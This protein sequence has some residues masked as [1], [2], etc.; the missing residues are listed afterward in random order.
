M[1][2]VR[3]TFFQFLQTRR[4]ESFR[5]TLSRSSGKSSPYLGVSSARRTATGLGA[6][7][8]DVQ[9]AALGASHATKNVFLFDENEGDAKAGKGK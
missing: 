1:I 4:T 7:L 3:H 5:Q 6:S 8:C 2:N 9:T